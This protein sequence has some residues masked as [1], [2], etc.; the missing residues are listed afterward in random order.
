MNE[1][2]NQLLQRMII[3]LPKLW[4]QLL[5]LLLLLAWITT[6]SSTIDTF[7]FD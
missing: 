3:R 6:T 1:L 5:R 2:I 4:Q 7:G